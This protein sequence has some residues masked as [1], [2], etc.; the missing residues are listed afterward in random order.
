MSES[1]TVSKAR[2]VDPAKTAKPTKR[3]AGKSIPGKSIPGG[4][5]AL[6]KAAAAQKKIEASS[7]A[8]KKKRRF[9]AGTVALREIRKYQRS[10]DNLVPAAPMERVVR[11]ILQE[12]GHTD[13]RLSKKGMAAIHEAAE[14]YLAEQFNV[15]CELAI[16][17]GG[18]TITA[19]DLAMAK[20]LNKA[21][22]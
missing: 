1:E 7:D 9:K 5:R 21:L 8:P 15:M 12:Q 13:I 10:T 18:V 2:K 4:R 6:Q 14:T 16:F 17:R 3:T 19:K 20:K 22:G 11:S